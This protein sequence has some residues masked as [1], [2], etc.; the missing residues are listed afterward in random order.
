M[1]LDVLALFEDDDDS[2]SP[3]FPSSANDVA[4]RTRRYGRL[5][6]D[7]IPGATRHLDF[8]GESAR[9]SER[10]SYDG[11]GDDA[12]SSLRRDGA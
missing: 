10:R 9:G 5:S 7:R 1:G 3:S 12:G 6:P 8:A 2:F 4:P 11:G